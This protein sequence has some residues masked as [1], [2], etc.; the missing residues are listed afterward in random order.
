MKVGWVV[1]GETPYPPYVDQW[2]LMEKEGDLEREYRKIEEEIENLKGLNFS[3][4]GGDVIRSPH[5]ALDLSRKYREVDV[6]VIYGV[7]GAGR[8]ALKAFVTY[9][10]PTI[11]FTKVRKDEMYGHA[12]YQQW[13]QKDALEPFT[14]VDL[15]INDYE[16]LVEKLRSHRATKILEESSVLCI[17]EP[18]DFF[19][20]E[21][22][23]RSAVKRFRSA[24][25]YLS[26]ETF[27]EELE[28]TNLNDEE[29]VKVKD[30]FLKNAENVSDEINEETALKSARTYV[31][32]K[33]L[34]R[35]GDYD[36]VTINCLSGILNVVETTPCLAFQRLR[37]EGIPA[38]CEADIPQLVTTILLQNIADRPT[39]INDP[40]ILPGENKIIVA[41]CTAPTK[42][43]GYDQ[44]A[45][46]YDALLH[47]ETKLGAAPSVK[48]KEG[49]EVTIAGVS[50]SFDE[51]IATKGCISRN[52]DYHICI[53]QAEV[54]VEDARF[55][56]DNFMG[57]HWV[58]VYGD[59]MEELKKTCDLLE[60]KLRFSGET[61]NK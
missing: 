57:F 15:V 29:V 61:R 33:R 21:L 3:V 4:I 1:L 23:A 30:K 13:Y 50:H 6:L 28:K 37:D 18:N 41:H 27:K 10:V 43:A 2:G 47:H 17:G 11:L 25:D 58:L 46:D 5:E 35:E 60:M 26:F 55:L 9:G 49:Q 19:K 8:E 44:E 16:S 59:W 12:L 24:V 54:E 7:S 39:F 32:L 20:G 40:V 45:E 36:A 52:T 56:F 22:A 34:I 42:M 31:V 38:V 53:T 48:L 14:E 51:M